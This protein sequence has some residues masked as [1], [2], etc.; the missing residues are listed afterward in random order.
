MLAVAAG[1][2]W[3]A[4]PQG[5]E[6]VLIAAVEQAGETPPVR[7]Q[8]SGAGLDLAGCELTMADAQGA[9]ALGK[10]PGCA[11]TGFA[12]AASWFE[13]AGGNLVLSGEGGERVAE[14]APDE[15]D[16]MVSVWPSHTIVM[17]TPAR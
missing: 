7:W 15:T 6:P 3:Y 1:A 4:A 16:G 2:I 12:R 14:F 11:A 10:S 17:L 9:G 13:D 5:G 8:V